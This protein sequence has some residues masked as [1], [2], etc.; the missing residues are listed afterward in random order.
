MFSSFWIGRRQGLLAVLLCGMLL[1][2]CNRD[3]QV[4]KQSF[5]QK[6]VEYL[7]KGDK[8]RAALEFANA[9]AIDPQFAEAANVLAEIRFREGDY[10]QA[11]T[12]L[13]RA[14]AAKPDYLPPHKGLAQLYRLSGKTDDAQKEIKFVLERSPN[15]IDALLNLGFLQ[16][17]RKKL[18]D[19][20]GTFNH[21]LELHPNH[22]G[23]LEGLASVKTNAGDLGAAERYLKLAVDTNPRSVPAHLALIRFYITSGRAAE[24]E[25]LFSKA[26]QTGMDDLRILEAQAGYY[27]GLKR[28]GDAEAVVQ[29]IQTSHAN[30]PKYW[31]ILGDF[32]VRIGDW[33]KAKV[34]LA[35]VHLLHKDNREALRKLIE[36]QL[37]LNDRKSAEALIGELLTKNAQDSYGHMFKGRLFLSAGQVDAAIAEFAVAQK[38]APNSAALH[39]WLAQGHIQKDELLAARQELDTALRYDPNHHDARLNLAKLENAAGAIESA[40]SDAARL[41]KSSPEDTDAMLVYGEALIRKGDYAAAKKIVR[42]VLNRAPANWEAHRLSGILFL[43]DKNLADARKE[44]LQAWNLQPQSKALLENVVLGY[45]A[46]KQPDAAAD[47]LR[48]AIR[49]RPGDALL[50]R[51]LGHVY[52]WQK[53]RAAAIPAFQKALGLSPADPDT[54]VL[55]ADTYIAEKQPAQAVQLIGDAVREHPNDADLMF[56]AGMI[57]EKLRLWE[58]AR[59]AYE[60]VIQLDSNRALA[61]NNLAWLL[62]EHG[63]N[64]DVALALAQQAK[65]K[66]NDSPHVNGTI[67]WIYF[68]KGI[69]QT[70][71]EYLKQ[72]VDKDQGNP[73]FHFQLGM[74]EWKLG[75]LPEARVALRKALRL[76]PGFPEAP[77]A[78]AALAQL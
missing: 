19:A 29:K 14:I 35:R 4:R 39:Y 70:A 75:N 55:L 7:N 48:N 78:R 43:S 40:L 69:Y 77:L 16:A 3:P 31:T 76:D 68:K 66:L 64:M 52:L 45:F 22:I 18:A 72:C 62:A 34:E 15:D 63:G 42:T 2:A 25:P 47:F 74:A 49:S 41:I 26:L 21:V 20:E 57:F 67:G 56:R 24:A 8:Q 46:A 32:Y 9:L 11:Y 51:E 53:N 5:Y 27:E 59:K 54:S 36:V 6:G 44:F 60:R 50:Y 28:F 61:K 71:R 23:A 17:Q 38:Y 73:T 12:L 30:D 10:R 33:D 1:P 37:T 65:E 58:D 13:E